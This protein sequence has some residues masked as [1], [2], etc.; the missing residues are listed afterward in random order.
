MIGILE[1]TKSTII[2]PDLLTGLV[3]YW[4]FD[5]NGVDIIGSKSPIL[6]TGITFDATGKINN[7][8]IGNE[9]NNQLL[10]YN[11]SDDFSFT[12]GSGNDLPF[13]FSFWLFVRALPL[14]GNWIINKRNATSGGDE[15]QV[16]IGGTSANSNKLLIYLFDR[17]SNGSYFELISVSGSFASPGS[18][19]RHVAITY[20]GS[21]NINGIKVYLNGVEE[22]MVRNVIGTYTGMNNG[23]ST[24]GFFNSNWNP[25]NGQR[26]LGRLDEFGIW[27]NRELTASEVA[28]LYNSGSGRAYPF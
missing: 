2:L 8:A 20:D 12:S 19:W 4:N 22:V 14:V 11:D 3:A 6:N 21:K 5:S 10:R 15:Y 26:H 23:P 1:Q 16:F 9:A 7:A 25:L 18:T 13:S 28:Y 24:L 17:N 27:K